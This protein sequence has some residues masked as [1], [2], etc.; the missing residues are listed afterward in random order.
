[1]R[2]GDALSATL[3][4]LVLHTEI[5]DIQIKGT[6]ENQ[7]TQLF[8]YANG[9]ARMSHSTAAVREL[10]QELEREGRI[11]GLQINEAKT[12]YLNISPSQA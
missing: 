5:Q 4:N 1:V 11:L 3:F 6:I 7:M 2:Q 8:G 10:F 9:S 12:K